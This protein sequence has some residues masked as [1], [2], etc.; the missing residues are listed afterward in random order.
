MSAI[1]VRIKNRVKSACKKLFVSFGLFVFIIIS[2]YNSSE[3][4]AANKIRE[5]RAIRVRY[6]N[7]VRSVCILNT[8]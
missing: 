7:R 5:I 3:R 1:R 4:P 6:K 2:C 8:E